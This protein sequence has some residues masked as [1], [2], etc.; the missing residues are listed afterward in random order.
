MLDKK[1]LPKDARYEGGKLVGVDREMN[2][3][4][5]VM[6]T[7]MINKLKN[8][9]PSVVK[10]VSEAKIEVIWLSRQIDECINPLHK[11]GFN[12]VTAISE[13]VQQMWMRLIYYG[14]DTLAK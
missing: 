2:L 11:S 4:K 1:Y 8:S 6:T 10:A 3:F 13:I 14:T 5:R 12:S 7:F 9:T